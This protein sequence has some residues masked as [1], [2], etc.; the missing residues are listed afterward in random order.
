MTEQPLPKPDA[1]KAIGDMTSMMSRLPEMMQRA[2][3]NE[4]QI[5]LINIKLTLILEKLG[6]DWR[7]DP[8]AQKYATAPK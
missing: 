6:V 1:A 5:N 8:R 3:A 2:D 7:S 4:R